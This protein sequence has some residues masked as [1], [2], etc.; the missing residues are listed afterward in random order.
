MIAFGVYRNPS[1]SAAPEKS[2]YSGRTASG[3]IS[4]ISHIGERTMTNETSRREFFQAAGLAAGLMAAAAPVPAAPSRRRGARSMGA[5]F[6]ALMTGPDPLI[7]ANAYDTMSARL[8]EVH[9]FKGVFPRQQRSE[10]GIC[11]AAGSGDRHGVRT[12]QLCHLVASNV[13]IPWSPTSTIWAPHR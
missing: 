7:C 6:R 2:L 12:R 1:A 5:R 10:P 4:T 3:A 9:G 13:N 11:R 8:I